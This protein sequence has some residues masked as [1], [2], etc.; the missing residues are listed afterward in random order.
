M[1][2]K[3]SHNSEKLKIILCAAAFIIITIGIIVVF[4]KCFGNDKTEEYSETVPV[5][6]IT[7]TTS[8]ATAEKTTEATTKAT[9]ETIVETTGSVSEVIT[10][11][12]TEEPAEE[13]TTEEIVTYQEDGLTF[14]NDSSDFVVLTDVVPD[15]VLEIRYYS[16]YNFVGEQIDGYEEPI[17]LVTTEAAEALKAVSDELSAQGYLLK[18][19]DA[20]RPQSAVS[21][22]VRWA[23]DTEDT[24]MKADFYPELDKS[25]LFSRGYIAKHS[26]HS[27]GS[28]LDLTLVY[29]DTK[30][31]VDMGGTFDY[32]GELSHSD[33]KGITE[34]QYANRMLLRKAMTS[35]GFNPYS[36]EWWHFTLSNEPYPGTYFT[37][38]V[39]SIVRK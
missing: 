4:D 33:Y 35:H 37:F 12:A 1:N 23:E 6:S 36:E 21:H 31:D 15:A 25:V 29:K 34:E 10:E 17:A 27:R 13:K 14:S 5:S 9:T 18:I 32:F 8:E 11:E 38:P 19:Y 22:F 39:S 26:G 2:H 28:T 7:E 16:S 3:Q 24:R 30:E 20:Y